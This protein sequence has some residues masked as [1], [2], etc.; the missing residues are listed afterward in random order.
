MASSYVF[1]S[2]DL[3]VDR[4]NIGSR[5]DLRRQKVRRRSV[6]SDRVAEAEERR[7]KLTIRV[8]PVSMA[9]FVLDARVTRTSETIATSKGMSQ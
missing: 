6:S 2:I 8:V 9:A 5:S 1:G 4:L 7:E 3:S